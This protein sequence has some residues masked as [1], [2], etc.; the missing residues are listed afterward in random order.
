MR[1]DTFSEKSPLV[2]KNLGKY[3]VIQYLILKIVSIV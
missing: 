3:Y 1:N 2:K